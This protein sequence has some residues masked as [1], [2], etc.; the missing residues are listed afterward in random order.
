M[1]EGTSVRQVWRH[2]AA[3][4]GMSSPT[5][6]GCSW[7]PAGC[8]NESVPR[9]RAGVRSSVPPDCVSGSSERERAHGNADDD[10]PEALWRSVCFA[11]DE[12]PHRRHERHRQ[13]HKRH[14]HKPTTRCS[15]DAGTCPTA[16]PPGESDR[17]NEDEQWY[18]KDDQGRDDN[19]EGQPDQPVHVERDHRHDSLVLDSHIH[20]P[21]RPRSP[22]QGCHRNHRRATFDN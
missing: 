15:T 12:E 22:R 20:E 7:T 5:E 6:P 1:L 18:R 3:E 17:S 10:E 8:W 16:T 11:R 2:R 13:H 9:R 19:E 21:S 4:V 14:N